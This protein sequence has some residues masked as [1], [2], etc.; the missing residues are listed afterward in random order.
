[1]HWVLLNGISARR[2]RAKRHARWSSIIV[3][4]EGWAELALG[5]VAGGRAALAGA[6]GRD[7]LLVACGERLARALTDLERPEDAA[8]LRARTRELAG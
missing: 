4:L 5:N 8:Y 1:M 3:A 7:P 2:R 6:R